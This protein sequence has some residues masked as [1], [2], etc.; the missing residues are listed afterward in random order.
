MQLSSD[1]CRAQEAH[2]QKLASDAQLDN[3]RTVALRA[4]SAWHLEAVS[5]E[6]R[7]QRHVRR[8]AETE[9]AETHDRTLSENPDRGVPDPQALATLSV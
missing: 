9:G 3:V 8:A 2:H 6:R 4:A 7:E 1:L 5:A